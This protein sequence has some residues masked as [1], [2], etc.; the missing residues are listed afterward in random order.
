MVHCLQKYHGE[1]NSL[2]NKLTIVG[3]KIEEDENVAILLCSMPSLWDELIMNLRPWQ[4]LLWSRPFSLCF[5]KT[6]IGLFIEK[7]V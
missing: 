5:P 2:I 3:I 7:L 4:I 6:E 1:F